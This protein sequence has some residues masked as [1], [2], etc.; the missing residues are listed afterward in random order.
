M[1]GILLLLLGALFAWSEPGFAQEESEKPYFVTYSSQM[2]EVG[3]LEIEVETAT[4]RPQGGNR[5][6][7]NP[8]EFEYGVSHWWTTELYIDWQHTS[9]EGNFYTGVRL[10]NRFRI[11]PGEHRIEPVL[12]LEY[13]NLNGAD[14]VL[15]E[16]VGFDGVEDLKVP[17]AEGRLE[18]VHEVEARLIL[19]G[20]FKSWD[21]SGNFITEKS[22]HAE[23]WEFGYAVGFSRPLASAS[24][25]KCAWC[26]EALSAGVEMYGGLGTRN[27][28]TLSGTSHYI[29]PV[30]AWTLPTDTTLRF[31]PGAGLTDQSLGT[32]F[33]FSVTQEIDDFGKLFTKPFRH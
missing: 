12:Y 25:R 22:L 5:F 6:F 30:I 27:T 17:S 32:L 21:F 11:I 19:S 29:A 9:H 15:K 24:G 8:T 10:E 28:F 18:R 1:R 3:S 33:R 2:E 14:K 23:P 4:G 31:S 20:Q 7:G 16:I 13:E 26:R